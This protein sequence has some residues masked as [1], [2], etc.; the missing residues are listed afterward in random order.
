MSSQTLPRSMWILLAVLTVGWGFNWPLMKMTLAE[1]PVW[2]FRGLCVGSGAIGLFIIARAT[3]QSIRVPREQ[4]GWLAVI[5]ICNV[6]LWNV[7][8]GYGLR[9]LPAGRSAILAY[10]MPIW[11]V[12]LSVFILHEK[13]TR[14]RI[15]GLLLGMAGM[16]VLLGGELSIMRT[17]PAGSM[18]VLAGAI[19]WA[20]G[21]VLMRRHPTTVSTTALTAWQLLIGGLPIMLGALVFDWGTWRPIGA[22]ATVGLVY[23]MTFVFIFCY[24]AWFKIATTAP[25]GVSSLSTLMIPV[26]GVFS[27]IWLLGESPRWQEYVALFLVISSLATVLI[28]PRNRAAA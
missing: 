11:A 1:L 2:T 13:L 12:L 28:A 10:S 14:R 25:P 23:N 4:W 8:I 24:W 15:L 5:S 27:G 7:F 18:L 19:A 3:R 17:S 22:G 16:A 21:T 9:M 6:T 26:V 20:L